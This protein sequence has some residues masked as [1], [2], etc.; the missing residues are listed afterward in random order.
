MRGKLAESYFLGG[1]VTRVT[2][3]I[4]NTDF[5]DGKVVLLVFQTLNILLFTI[6]IISKPQANN[7]S[8]AGSEGLQQCPDKMC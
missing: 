5:Y 1:R 4:I 8:E 6:F 7:Q 2:V 3:A